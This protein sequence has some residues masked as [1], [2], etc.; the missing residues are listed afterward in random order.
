M[1][2]IKRG[3]IT[4]KPASGDY[5]LILTIIPSFPTAMVKPYIVT[6]GM[7]GSQARLLVGHTL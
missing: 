3:V 1:M 5:V 7:I 2:I 6:H 4:P